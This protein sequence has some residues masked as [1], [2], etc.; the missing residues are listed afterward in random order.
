MDTPKIA[1]KNPVNPPIIEFLDTKARMTGLVREIYIAR[2]WIRDTGYAEPHYELT[3]LGAK[4]L[5]V[6]NQ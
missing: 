3:H 2:G 1:K 5:Q 6:E 4:M